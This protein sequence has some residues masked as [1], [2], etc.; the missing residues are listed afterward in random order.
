VTFFTIAWLFVP[1]KGS[2]FRGKLFIN[3]KCAKAQKA[4]TGG[5]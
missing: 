1:V 5:K 3:I 2:I 4:L